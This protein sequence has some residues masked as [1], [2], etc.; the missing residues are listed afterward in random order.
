[1]RASG[2]E[3]AGF[4]KDRAAGLAVAGSLGFAAELAA[5]R[6]TNGAISPLLNATAFGIV[7]GNVLRIND[8][9]LKSL[10]STAVG[11]KFAK[12][13]LLRAGIILYGAK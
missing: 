4:V 10:S 12:Q 5:K 8:P 11:M 2:R 1:M 3:A 7:I 6:L 13:R 9:E